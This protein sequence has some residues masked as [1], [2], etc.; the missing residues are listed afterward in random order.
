MWSPPMWML[1]SG[2]RACTS[3]SRGA[4]ATCSSTNSG[5]RITFG[6]ST[7]WPAAANTST[8]S[9]RMNSTPIS[10]TMRRHPLSSVAIAS[11][12]RISYRGILLT[13]IRAL[14]TIRNVEQSFHIMSQNAMQTGT[15]AIDRA[16]QLLV[17]VVEN[18]ESS[19]VG[20]LAEAAGLPKSTVSRALSALERQGLVQREGG[21]GGVRPGP[22]L[23]SLARRGVGE[24]DIV[25]RC[26]EALQRLGDQSGETIDLAVPVPGG[27]ER[28]LAQVDS[29]HFLGTTN[30]VGRRLPNHCT[31]VGKVFM[32]FGATRLPKAP[33][34]R[35]TADTITDPA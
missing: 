27:A 30:W 32:A 28:Y 2:F 15:Q 3:N 22:V 6:P 34:E 19:S 25:E 23:L 9:G 10:L 31:A 16:A 12:E 11:S 17:L 4:L 1:R 26:A 8:A 29:S 18:E 35:M 24:D 7:F 5:S 13:N 21:R 33:L 20:E 14:P